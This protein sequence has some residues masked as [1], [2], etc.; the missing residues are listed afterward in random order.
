MAIIRFADGVK[1]NI[2]TQVR[3]AIDAGPAAGYI[4]IYSGSMPATPATAI[5]AGNTLLGTLTFSDPC[6]PAVPTG[7]PLTASTVTQDSAADA[8]GV[9]SWVRVKDS[10]GA[11]VFDADAG[12]TG[13]G[14]LVQFNTVNIVLGGPIIC[15]S[16]TLTVP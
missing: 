3:T 14:A 4:E 16:F 1:T 11:V 8:T 10:T 15:T 9:A 13:G 12:T 7:G 5:G 2:L 6:S